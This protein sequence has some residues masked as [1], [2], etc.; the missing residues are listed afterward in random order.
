MVRWLLDQ[1][2]ANI[3]YELIIVVGICALGY[4]VILLLIRDPYLTEFMRG[5][6]KR[7]NKRSRQLLKT[8]YP[9]CG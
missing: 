9:R 3:I 7:I 8:K 6:F 4:F 1:Y 5:L 2:V